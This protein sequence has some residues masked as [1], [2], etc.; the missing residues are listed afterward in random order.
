MR[1]V[2]YEHICVTWLCMHVCRYACA[3]EHACAAYS[4]SDPT[5]STFNGTEKGR[6]RAGAQDLALRTLL[7]P[8]VCRAAGP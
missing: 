4:E 2:G 7:H 3:C 5:V 6:S 8:A 1:D